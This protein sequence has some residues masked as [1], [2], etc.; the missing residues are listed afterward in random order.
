M[1]R[2][3]LRLPDR[4]ICGDPSDMLHDVLALHWHGI[5]SPTLWHSAECILVA[6]QANNGSRAGVDITI[7]ASLDRATGIFRR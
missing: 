6:I 4:L 3:L 7:V 1:T 5:C 2:L